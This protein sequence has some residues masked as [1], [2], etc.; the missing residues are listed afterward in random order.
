MVAIIAMADRQRMVSTEGWGR[1][2]A[3]F[4]LLPGAPPW[5]QKSFFAEDLARRSPGS[6]YRAPL[7]TAFYRLISL[8][9]EEVFFGDG[10]SEPPDV[11]FYDLEKPRSAA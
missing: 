1:R 2:T 8:R 5:R 9:S 4:R 11:G 3:F 6:P 7:R 10:M